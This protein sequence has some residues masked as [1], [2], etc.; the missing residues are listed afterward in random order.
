MLISLDAETRGVDG[1]LVTGAAMKAGSNRGT[2]LRATVGP[3]ELIN[4]TVKHKKSWCGAMILEPQAVLPLS[5]S[6]QGR[7]RRPVQKSQ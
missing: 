2:M 1:R 4:T 6:A 5:Y 7:R 3:M